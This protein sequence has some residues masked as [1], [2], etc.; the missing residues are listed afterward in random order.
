MKEIFKTNE[1]K[2]K[3]VSHRTKR[4]FRSGQ[5]QVGVVYEERKTDGRRKQAKGH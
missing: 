3:F 4:N 5:D 1:L 2:N